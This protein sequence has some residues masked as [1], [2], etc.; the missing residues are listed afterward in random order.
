VTE[1]DVLVVMSQEAYC[2]NGGTPIIEQYL[3]RVNGIQKG[4]RALA[5]PATRL[6][7]ELGRKVVLNIV[8]VGFFAA[9]TGL[10]EAGALHKAISDSVPPHMEKLNL[11]AFKK[12]FDYG[13]Q[14][15][16]R[17]AESGDA[18][19]HR[20]RAVAGQAFDTVRALSPRTG[21]HPVDAPPASPYSGL[22]AVL[23][24]TTP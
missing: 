8:M 11:K 19:P 24:H 12:G 22:L 15:L 5:C 3:V 17:L 23:G 2:R 4:T 6:A 7:E 13:S 1:P 18:E 14:T 9:L 10:I 16:D 21:F 20:S